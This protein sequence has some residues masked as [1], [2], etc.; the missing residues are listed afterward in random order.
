M[1]RKI[2]IIGAGISGLSTGCYLQMNG[3]DTEIYEMH[4]LPGGLCTAWERK[5][6]TIDGCIH[7]LAGSKPGESFYDLWNELIDM[8]SVR[9]F[10]Y[11]EYLRFEDAQGKQLTVFTDIDKLEREMLEKAPQDRKVIEEFIGA[12]RKLSGFK[13]PIGK[14]REL[15]GFGDKARLL[16][17]ILPYIRLFKKWMSISGSQLAAKCESP[18]LKQTFESMF[19]SDMAALFLVFMMVL[20]NK[21]NAGYPIGGSLE[22]ARRIEKKYLELGGRMNYGSKVTKI[23]TEH[24][25]GKA[26]IAKGVV[27][28]NGQIC[29]GD[30]VI[31]AADGHFTIFEM[32]GGKFV[33]EKIKF[34][35][36]NFTTFPSYLQISLGLSRTFEGLPCAMV[37]E[38][39]KPI[40]IDAE[41]KRDRIGF[42]TFNFDP[43][44]APKGKTV[45]TTF[46]TTPNYEY[47]EG[48][49]KND[50]EKYNAEKERIAGEVV[51]VLED[52]M[53]NI[54]N[55][56][57]MIDVAT[58]ATVIRYTN[59]WKGSLEGWIL[60]PKM[61]FTQ[62]SKTLPGL[63]NF[64]MIGQWVEPGG[65]LPTAILSGRNVAQ[66][67]C[68]QDGKHFSVISEK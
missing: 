55:H 63:D 36:E 66:I 16:L 4:S 23:I 10:E 13:M 1:R 45:V 47:W 15:Y 22:F 6:Y 35:Y 43:T 67:I 40:V 51:G 12:A 62:M 8:K 30:I 46:L 52:K 9:F 17:G 41:T 48:L 53:G 60:S 5:G 18:L 58:P 31:S 32:L 57:E 61:G 24:S 2:V 50:R 59:N 33:D 37:Y 44:L 14:A 49:R 34:Y 26:N 29:S 65:G 56:I 28:E 20:M 19:V 39:K 25:D 54:K 21:K 7:W 38:L 3:Y 11:E 64:Y 27:L 68:N 42:R